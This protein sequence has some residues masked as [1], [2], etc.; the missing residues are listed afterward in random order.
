MIS[1]GQGPTIIFLDQRHSGGDLCRAMSYPAPV[2]AEDASSVRRSKKTLRTIAVLICGLLL[3]A[4]AFCWIGP[5]L[6]PWDDLKPS[7]IP[8]LPAGMKNGREFL[9]T[10]WEPLRDWLGG[11]SRE[12]LD[13]R[14]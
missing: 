1:T 11:W 4:G 8:P 2:H 12:K 5:P 7:T 6:Q 3:A 10:K 9:K 14:I 13:L